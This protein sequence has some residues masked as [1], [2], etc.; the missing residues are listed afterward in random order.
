MVMVCN[1]GRYIFIVISLIIIIS[2]LGV[3]FGDDAEDRAYEY[4]EFG[5]EC[6][7][8]SLWKE[9]EYRFR[10]SLKTLPDNPLIHN[11]LAVTLEAQQRLDEAYEEYKRANELAP[12][13]EEIYKNFSKFLEIHKYEEE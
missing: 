7:K 9:A 2:L 8:L 11:N 10:Q 12:D 3:S 5:I 6:M 4:N 13:D 1:S